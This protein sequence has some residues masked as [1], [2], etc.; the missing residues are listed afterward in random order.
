MFLTPKNVQV[1][2]GIHFENDTSLAL[3]WLEWCLYRIKMGIW[4]DK[5]SCS[6]FTIFH[7]ESV[8]NQNVW[9]GTHPRTYL[10]L[11]TYQILVDPRF[12]KFVIYMIHIQKQERTSGKGA[13]PL[14]ILFSGGK[15]APWEFTPPLCLQCISGKKPPWVLSGEHFFLFPN[16]P[17]NVQSLLNI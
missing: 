5:L 17:K 8:Q 1:R 15:F 16:P 11:G 4:R 13:F 7:V 6:F 9:K 3:T 10:V 14:R 2:S 12:R